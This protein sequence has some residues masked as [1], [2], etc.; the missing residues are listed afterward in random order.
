[1][2]TAMTSTHIL[3]RGGGVSEPHGHG[4]TRGGSSLAPKGR[5]LIS[6]VL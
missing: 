2:K 1:M 5:H 4:L 3:N 6:L